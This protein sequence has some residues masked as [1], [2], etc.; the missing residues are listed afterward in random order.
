MQAEAG[1]A[2]KL[3]RRGCYTQ[4][5]SLSKRNN[6][7]KESLTSHRLGQDRRKAG[8]SLCCGWTQLQRDSNSGASVASPFCRVT[9]RMPAHWPRGPGSDSLP[10]GHRSQPPAPTIARVSSPAGLRWPLSAGIVRSVLM[11]GALASSRLLHPLG[12]IW[13]GV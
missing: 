3:S 12:T 1:P 4:G 7:N 2:E 9:G 11:R 10:S 6:R 13:A 8:L 5:V